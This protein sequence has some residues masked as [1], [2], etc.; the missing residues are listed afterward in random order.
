MTA[1]CEHSFPLATPGAF[2]TAGPCEG[3]GKTRERVQADEALR[4]AVAAMNATEPERPEIR[5]CY[6]GMTATV[7]PGV[8]PH[9]DCDGSVLAAGAERELADLRRRVAEY[10][11]AIGWGTSCTACARVLDSAVSETFRREEAER[12]LAGAAAAA[13][14]RIRELADRTGAVCTG[15]EGTSFYF[16]ALLADPEVEPS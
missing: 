12:K 7:M 15:R 1:A 5:T 6:C 4:E 13:R 10:E 14:K 16:S 2:G 3:C 8:F 9:S 11:N